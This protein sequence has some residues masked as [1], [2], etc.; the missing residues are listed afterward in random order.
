M[1]D[2]IMHGTMSGHLFVM[3]E[4]TI[5]YFAPRQASPLYPF[6]RINLRSDEVVN[7]AFIADEN[8]EGELVNIKAR[9]SLY[10]QEDLDNG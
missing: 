4:T 10:K 2:D 3:G 9:L 8:F 1:A 6:K 5:K 7:K